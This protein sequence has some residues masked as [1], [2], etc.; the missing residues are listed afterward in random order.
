MGSIPLSGTIFLENEMKKKK[1]SKQ[2]IRIQE[3]ENQVNV[4]KNTCNTLDRNNQELIKRNINLV[5][6]MNRTIKDVST[7]LSSITN[8]LAQ[9]N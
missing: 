7:L 9:V 5:M 3:L 4:L 6:L 1:L 2:E 8:D